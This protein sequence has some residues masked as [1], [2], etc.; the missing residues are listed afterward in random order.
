MCACVRAGA[1]AEIIAIV[2]CFS[3]IIYFRTT[4]CGGSKLY[5][6][7]C[8]DG[9]KY[10]CENVSEKTLNASKFLALLLRTENVVKQTALQRKVGMNII[11]L[12]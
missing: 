5:H 9:R 2:Q 11:I 6:L 10:L 8:I 7:I 3:N 12:F 4:Q 1:R